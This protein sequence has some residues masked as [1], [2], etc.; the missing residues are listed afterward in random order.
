MNTL[1]YLTISLLSVCLVFTAC[2]LD[3]DETKKEKSITLKDLSGQWNLAEAVR[4][5]QK[6]GSLEGTFMNFKGNDQLSCNFNETGEAIESAFTL[7]DNTL[8]HNEQSYKVESFSESELVVSTKLM[9]FNFKLTFN[10]AE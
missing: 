4:D 5:G 3:G 1:K 10:K 9:D 8:T 6:T 7:K 2:T